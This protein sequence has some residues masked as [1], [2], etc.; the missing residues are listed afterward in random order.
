MFTQI[1]YEQ[2]AAILGC[3][4]RSV[5]KLVAK[6]ELTSSGKRGGSLDREN[7]EALAVRRA[8]ER[9]ARSARPPREYERVDHRPDQD[10]DWLTRCKVAKLLSVTIQGVRHRIHRGKLPAVE[11]GGRL[12]VRRDLLEQ[13]EAARLAA[14]LGG[15]GKGPPSGHAHPG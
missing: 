3:H 15:P 4:V 11:N 1:S 6:G 5:A 12:W 7:V 10:H 13:V 2:A 8:E 14:G 9:A